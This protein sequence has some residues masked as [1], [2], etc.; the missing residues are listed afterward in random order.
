LGSFASAY[1]NATTGAGELASSFF[2]GTSRTTLAVNSALTDGTS[3]LKSMAASDVSDALLD[4]TRSFSADGLTL[5]N[6]T[7]STLV[8]SSL[9]GFQQAASNIATL[10][11]TADGSRTYLQ[12]K[13]TNETAVNTDNELV[14]LVNYQN[15]YAAS[16]HVM[17]VIQE[18]F[19]TLQNLL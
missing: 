8:T 14:S 4:S 7:Y 13:L 17:S 2:V 10:S 6:T 18:L 3:A 16:A 19:Q 12:E 15:A 5:T 1:N 11:T 9:T